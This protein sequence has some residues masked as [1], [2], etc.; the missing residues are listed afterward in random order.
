MGSPQFDER[1]MWLPT[2]SSAEP[3][4]RL[5][6]ARCKTGVCNLACGAEARNGRSYHRREGGRQGAG[7][8]ST[9]RSASW[10]SL[11]GTAPRI[12]PRIGLSP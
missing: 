1:S 7:T 8:A 6:T 4:Q 2:V 10:S 9:G 5:K 3:V 12:A 11:W